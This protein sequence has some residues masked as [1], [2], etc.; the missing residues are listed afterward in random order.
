MAPRHDKVIP[1][2][3]VAPAGRVLDEPASS[4]I[5]GDVY[6]LATNQT[7]TN[8]TNCYSQCNIRDF[9]LKSGHQRTF[10]WLRDMDSVAESSHTLVVHLLTPGRLF[11]PSLAPQDAPVPARQG[12]PTLGHLDLLGFL[13]RFC[14]LTG[15][16]SGKNRCQTTWKM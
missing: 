3:R 12:C 6:C 2:M 14:S 7:S 1:G 16:K 11:S 4:P 13:F 8:M 10:S 9:S 15:L 5:A